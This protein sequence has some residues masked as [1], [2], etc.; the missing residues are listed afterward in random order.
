[1]PY[2]HMNF[3][4]TFLRRPAVTGAIAPSSRWLAARITED[5]KLDQA[6]TVVELGPGTGAFTHAI[7]TQLRSD[8]LLLA[9][10]INPEFASDLARRF[11]RAHVVN[12]SA[13]KL[14]EHLARLGRT[15]VDCVLSGLPWACFSMDMQKRLLGAVIRTLRP[16]GQFATFAYIHG[17]WLPP[18]RR[19]RRLL[20]S[21]FSHVRT[22]RTVWRNLPPA[23]VYRCE[24]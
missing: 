14:D 5:M 12:E 23:F 24:K 11:P 22:S 1:M 13:E 19:F 8:A 18:G 7:Q 3:L 4:S 9:M 6:E 21:S 15:S 17:C 16:G 2:E 10:E 20:E